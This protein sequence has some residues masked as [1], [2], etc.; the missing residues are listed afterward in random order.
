MPIDQIMR[1]PS[2]DAEPGGTVADVLPR[3]AREVAEDPH[4]E[5]GPVRDSMRAHG[6]TYPIHIDPDVG[7]A[8][9][10]H[11]IVIARQL[12]WKSMAYSPEVLDTGEEFEGFK[13]ERR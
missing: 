13:A 12:G 9:G 6:Q 2:V 8:N 5:F 3:K 7:V 10:H 4:H 11:R 1:L